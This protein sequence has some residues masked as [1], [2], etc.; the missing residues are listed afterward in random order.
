MIIKREALK[1]AAVGTTDKEKRWPAMHAVQIRP[2]GTIAATDGRV[3]LVVS[4]Q[5]VFKDADFPVKGVPLYKGNPAAAILLPASHVDRLIKAMPKRSPIPILSTVQLTMNGDGGAVVS[6]TDLDVPC[7]VHLPAVEPHSFPQVERAFPKADR[8]SVTVRLAIDVLETLIKSAKAIGAG[9]IELTLP[10]EPQYQERGDLPTEYEASA[11]ED[12][13]HCGQPEDD[14]ASRYNGVGKPA[15]RVCQAPG[16][17]M[18]N[19]VIGVTIAH[20]D[21]TVRGAAMPFAKQ[22]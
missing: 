9:Q 7:T 5:A 3:A 12:C 19:S 11:T 15:R 18:I 20:G 10:T 14:H 16:N 13:A 1:A 2:D 4:D 22:R 8:P 6:A 21:L 17:G